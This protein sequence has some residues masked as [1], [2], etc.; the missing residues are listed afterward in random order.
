MKMFRTKY[1]ALS[2]I[3]HFALISLLI[4]YKNI[5]EKAQ[6][7]ML[8]TEI[9]K[10]KESSELKKETSELEKEKSELNNEKKTSD[11]EIKIVN[12]VNVKIKKPV[13]EQFP[14]KINLKSSNITEKRQSNKFDN[15]K[16]K[17]NNKKASGENRETKVIYSPNNKQ[18]VDESNQNNNLSKASYKIGSIK[19]PHPPYPIVA[20][21]KGLQG[22]LVLKVSIN[23][24][25]SVKNVVVGKSSGHKIL[26]KV[27]KE[28]VEKWVFIPAKKMGKPVE[29]NIKV[30]IRFVLTE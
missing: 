5:S 3:I 23:N 25:G 6:T 1:F 27:S 2:F 21:K 12:K 28:T 30:P 9:I 20:R 10:I 15:K 22:K 29:A 17:K 11:S 7:T 13:E 8:V 14:N 16:I 19:N 18:I 24:D 26:D 4:T